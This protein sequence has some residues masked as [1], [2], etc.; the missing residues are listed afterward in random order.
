MS[1]ISVE[2]QET[3]G[4]PWVPLE[5][6]HFYDPSDTEQFVCQEGGKNSLESEIIEDTYTEL[7]WG[8]LKN[9]IDRGD[10][11]S[12][13]EPKQICIAPDKICGGQSDKD[14][15]WSGWNGG[16]KGET[17]AY[18]CSPN[19]NNAT[20]YALVVVEPHTTSLSTATEI[21]QPRPTYIMRG[22]TMRIVKQLMGPAIRKVASG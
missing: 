11:A 8:K 2:I 17:L 22:D 1:T 10:G 7:S 18:K 4:G 13:T 19:A 9:I 16:I 20:P 5:L 12:G 3:S 21:V 15:E 14:G 6:K